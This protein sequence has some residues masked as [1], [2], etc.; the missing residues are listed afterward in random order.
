MQTKIKPKCWPD[1]KM[2]MGPAMSSYGWIAPCCWML[3]YGNMNNNVHN[4]F[5]ESLKISNIR[6]LDDIFESEQWKEFHRML[7]EEP[8]NMCHTCKNMC[9]YV[10]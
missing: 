1:S 10:C 2:Q 8:E 3:S 4:L 7:E 5:D 9:G 6:N